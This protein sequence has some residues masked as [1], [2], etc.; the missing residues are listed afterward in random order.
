SRERS[1][2]NPNA[3]LFVPAAVQQVEDFSPE[4]WNLVTT[5]TWFHDYW[6]N[7]QQ[8]EYSFCDNADDDE[9]DFIDIV[10]EDVWAMESQYEQFLLSSESSSSKQIPTNG[11]ENELKPDTTG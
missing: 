3:P 4:W 7:Q 9:F 2:L 10:D 8:G 5:S 11:V 1:T 6:L